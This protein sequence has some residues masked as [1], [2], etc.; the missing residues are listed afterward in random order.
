MR[1]ATKFEISVV[2]VVVVLVLVVVV[3]LNSFRLLA[4]GR[5]H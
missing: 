2:V 4:T 3:L 5:G 1:L